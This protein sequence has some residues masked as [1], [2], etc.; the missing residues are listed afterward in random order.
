MRIRLSVEYMAGGFTVLASLFLWVPFSELLVDPGI[1]SKLRLSTNLE[2]NFSNGTRAIT[3]V[4]DIFSRSEAAAGTTPLLTK[5][6][7]TNKTFNHR[8]AALPDGEFSSCKQ[9]E[10]R[11]WELN[12]HWPNRLHEVQ[13]A[14]L[15]CRGVKENIAIL[16][17]TYSY[18]FIKRGHGFAPQNPWLNNNHSLFR[19]LYGL[20]QFEQDR[21][22]SR[23]NAAHKVFEMPPCSNLLAPEAK[24]GFPYNPPLRPPEKGTSQIDPSTYIVTGPGLGVVPVLAAEGPLAGHVLLPRSIKQIELTGTSQLSP[25]KAGLA[26]HIVIQS[27]NNNNSIPVDHNSA[28]FQMRLFGLTMVSGEVVAI[29]KGAYNAT[30]VVRDPGDY[31]LEVFCSWVEE[32]VNGVSG[33]TNRGKGFVL[34][35]VIYRSEHPV[36]VAMLGRSDGQCAHAPGLYPLRTADGRDC[37]AYKPDTCSRSLA[38]GRWV[39][40]DKGTCSSPASTSSEPVCTLSSGQDLFNLEIM[41]PIGLNWGFVWVP[42]DNCCRLHLFNLAAIE[43]CAL[44]QTG[45]NETSMTFKGDSVGREMLQNVQLI[46]SNFKPKSAQPKLKKDVHVGTIF[47]LD[48]GFTGPTRNNFVHV[49]QFAAPHILL[50][51]G[52]R[53]PFPSKARV[54]FS[55]SFGV[56]VDTLAASCKKAGVRHCFIYLDPPLQR[57]L[58]HWKRLE[59]YNGGLKQQESMSAGRH[60]TLVDQCLRSEAV[61]RA[62]GGGLAILDGYNIGRAHW[63]G[64]WDGLHYSE[65]ASHFNVSNGWY[66][67]VSSMIT[68]V[69]LNQVCGAGAHVPLP[70]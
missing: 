5:M 21:R 46:A 28:T 62:R 10:A 26:T 56:Q 67:G 12:R 6:A 19:F 30:F 2:S 40:V 63:W 37:T 45:R 60:R 22:R 54:D 39:Y 34:S 24:G 61:S 23:M 57:L 18:A 64:S 43:A 59:N 4:A 42:F 65:M 48:V 31:V 41:D 44:R 11:V 17:Q 49:S 68:Q 53:G 29:G 8:G 15:V 33:K 35:S 66:G 38:E 14:H 55:R 58:E 32:A 3:S 16:A 52:D 70:E 36:R 1:S 51:R 47:S 9:S 50:D 27:Y 20:L 13:Q 25:L 7:S 69:L